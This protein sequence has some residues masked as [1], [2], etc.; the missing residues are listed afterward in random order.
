M[1]I[2]IQVLR[3]KLEFTKTLV[4]E[5]TKLLWTCTQLQAIIMIGATNIHGKLL[6]V[7]ARSQ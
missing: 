1:N 3:R 7:V 4:F 2:H 5:F 6:Y